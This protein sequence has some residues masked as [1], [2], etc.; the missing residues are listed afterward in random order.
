MAEMTKDEVKNL[1]PK[2]EPVRIPNY[3]YMRDQDREL[4]TGKFIYHEV[5]G[6]AFEFVY[7]C[8][9]GDE[10][11]KY[12]MV[13]GGIY[14]IPRGVAKHLN[15]NVWYPQYDYVPG[16]S[17]IGAVTNTTPHGNHIG[18]LMRI[19]KKVRRVSFMS[20]EFLDIEGVP[21]STPGIV[22]VEAANI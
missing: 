18:K 12:S 6:G 4:V 19:T 21:T 22:T 3:K 20:M 13:D 8:Y 9:K 2:K 7:K 15:N 1:T 11:E 5:P 10:V 14:K 17:M 16:E